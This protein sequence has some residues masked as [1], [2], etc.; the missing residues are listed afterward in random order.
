MQMSAA[1]RDEERKSHWYAD[2]VA[3]G[4]IPDAAKLREMA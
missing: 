2:L 3:D 1:M 4:M